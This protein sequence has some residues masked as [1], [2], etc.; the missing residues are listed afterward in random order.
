MFLVCG[1][2]FTLL[3]AGIVAGAAVAVSYALPWPASHAVTWL[4][5]GG[6]FLACEFPWWHI[7]TNNSPGDAPLNAYML[8]GCAV[9]WPW[10]RHHLWHWPLSPT[11]LRRHA[12]PSYLR[13]RKLA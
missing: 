13:R 8:R 2:R 3:A 4:K 1:P 5:Y 10:T 7:L 6:V 11:A 12:S 9:G